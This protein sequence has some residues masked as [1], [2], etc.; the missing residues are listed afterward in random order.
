MAAALHREVPRLRAAGELKCSVEV[1]EKLIEIPAKT[2]DRLL[3]REEQARRI[4]RPR[5]RPSR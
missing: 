4:N 2:I 1:A 5:S 3:Q